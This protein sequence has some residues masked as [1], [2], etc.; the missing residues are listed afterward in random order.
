MAGSSFSRAGGGEKEEREGKEGKKEREERERF[1]FKIPPRA[2]VSLML[3]SLC[4][5]SLCSAASDWLHTQKSTIVS[6]DGS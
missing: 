2:C 6:L 5:S 3:A 4:S 1:L